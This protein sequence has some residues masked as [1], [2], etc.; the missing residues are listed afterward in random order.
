MTERAEPPMTFGGT[1]GL[2]WRLRPDDGALATTLAPRPSAPDALRP[3]AL[4]P[5]T[6]LASCGRR[7]DTALS[8]E[9]AEPAAALASRVADR[10]LASAT[11][12][13]SRA[14]R[15][16]RPRRRP[17][18]R[19]LGLGLTGLGRRVRTTAST[20]DVRARA[21][22]SAATP[23]APPAA[24]SAAAS[25]V[26]RPSLRPAPK[27]R[28]QRARRRAPARPRPDEGGDLIL[29]H[30]GGENAA[31]LRVTRLSLAHPTRDAS[32]RPAGRALGTWRSGPRRPCNPYSDRTRHPSETA[33]CSGRRPRPAGAV[34]DARSPRRGAVRGGRRR[35][36]TRPARSGRAGA[37]GRRAAAR[38]TRAPEGR[39]CGRSRPS[40]RARPR[41]SR[42]ITACP[43]CWCVRER[44]V[45]S[46]GPLRRRGRGARHGERPGDWDGDGW[47]GCAYAAHRAWLYRRRRKRFVWLIF[48]RGDEARG[49]SS[50]RDATRRPRRAMAGPRAR[51]PPCRR[52]VGR[53]SRVSA[54]PRASRRR[55]RRHAR[56]RRPRA[57]PYAFSRRATRRSNSAIFDDPRRGG[58]VA[59]TRP[60]GC[61]WSRRR[62]RRGTPPRRRDGGR[63]G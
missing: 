62:G 14:R 7:W 56:E 52:L 43:R 6:R 41:T 30:T 42:S 4:G 8:P 28:C 37:P 1:G 48:V 35:E 44:R 32:T 45:A 50:R 33:R 47:S 25:S 3:R 31:E 17:L 2:V 63:R 34:R 55:R 51:G 23:G 16:P 53:R 24:C 22:S 49:T 11:H 57:R 13:A 27:A 59:T 9:R 60:R 10:A 12:P 54:T 36:G 18:R 20:R 15:R 5:P 19:R 29:A 39:S 21:A 26:P 38:R 46:R 58:D 40:T 61:A